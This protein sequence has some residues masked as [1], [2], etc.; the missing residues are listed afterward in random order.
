MWFHAKSPAVLVIHMLYFTSVSLRMYFPHG[1]I[2]H[3]VHVPFITILERY[4]LKHMS[5]TAERVI[6]FF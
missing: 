6:I 1:Y 3:I 4:L 2:I 5:S